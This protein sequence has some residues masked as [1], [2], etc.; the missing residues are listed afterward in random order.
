MK[1]QTLSFA[2]E[3]TEAQSLSKLIKAKQLVNSKDGIK[4]LLVTTLGNNFFKPCVFQNTKFRRD[5]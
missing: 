5:F 2:N 3:E 1:V 4:T